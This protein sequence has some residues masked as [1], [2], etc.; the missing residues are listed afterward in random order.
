MASKFWEEDSDGEIR[1][2]SGLPA[3][4]IARLNA[5]T[6]RKGLFL[7]IEDVPEG[8]IT[9]EIA[10]N[11][12]LFQNGQL[13]MP[14]GIILVFEKNGN[15]FQE[16]GMYFCDIIAALK[17]A[18]EHVLSIQVL[19]AAQYGSGGDEELHFHHGGKKAVELD[20]DGLDT[21]LSME[22]GKE[23]YPYLRTL[24]NQVPSLTDR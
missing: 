19:R 2:A 7:L 23:L 6:V 21:L 10:G 22:D 9:E 15:T 20:G 18:K 8:I 17:W 4:R 13:L 11:G 16:E 14:I 12:R 5:V 1:F 3:D 24:L